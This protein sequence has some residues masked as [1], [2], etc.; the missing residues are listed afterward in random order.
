[1]DAYLID[2]GR[3]LH[4]CGNNPDCPGYEIEEG[5]FRLK[6]YEGPVLACDKCGSEM[7]LKSGRFGKYFGCVNE[8]CG[9]TRKLLRN[10]Q[11]APPRSDPVPLPELRCVKVD[12]FYL[13]RDGAAGIFLAAS[14]F[15]KNRETRAPLVSELV[16]HRAEIAEKHRYLLDAPERDPAGRPA[17]IR[18]SRK[19]AEH[20]VQSE[21]EGKPSG[22][23]AFFVDGAWRA[24]SG[25]ADAARKPAAKKA[26]AKK[27]AVRKSATKKSAAK[28]PA[29]KKPAAKNGA[30]K[31]SAS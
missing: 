8:A 28:K 10:G 12:D 15:P 31:K 21:V 14:K 7:Q 30:A 11:A 9:N 27:P 20:F 4:V 6:G 24:E 18:Y 23:R 29:A 1:M 5:E 19:T 17:V 2:A 3:K 13:L 16:P 25:G 26:A 22:W